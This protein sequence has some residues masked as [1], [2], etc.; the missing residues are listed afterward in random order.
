MVQLQTE[1]GIFYFPSPYKSYQFGLLD[2]AS[3]LPFVIAIL[4]IPVIMI[5]RGV[6]KENS[7]KNISKFI[8]TANSVAYFLLIIL[9]SYWGFYDIL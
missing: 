8:F 1:M 3:Y 6:L 9:F 5:N 4:F 2:I 7:W